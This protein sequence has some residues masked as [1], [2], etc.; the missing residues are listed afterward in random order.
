MA[1]SERLGLEAAA[2]HTVWDSL[3]F[4]TWKRLPTG[5]PPAVVND[6]GRWFGTHLDTLT[7]SARGIATAGPFSSI[8]MYRC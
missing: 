4:S 7:A 5:E 6:W 3:A 8:T 1:I 2:I